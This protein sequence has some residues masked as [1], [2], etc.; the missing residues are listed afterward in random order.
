MATATEVLALAAAELGY[1]RWDDPAEGTKYGRWYAKVTGSPYFGTSG[2]AF[3]AMGVSYVLAKAGMV[4][5]G[6]IFAYVPYGINN[7]KNLG[8]LVPV[9]AAQPGDLICFDWDNDGLSDHVGF[10]ELNRGSYVQTIEF[11]TS[12]SHAGSQSNSGGVYRR[13]RYWDSVCAVIRPD[14]NGAASI[15]SGEVAEFE[16]VPDG[17]W[18]ANTNRD[19]QRSQGTTQD[20][21]I[22]S[23]SA[24]WRPMLVACTSGWEFVA[25]AEA[26]GSQL[27]ASMQRDMGLDP[28]A[29]AGVDFINALEVRYGFD[30]DGCLDGPSPTVRAMQ[31]SLAKR[32]RF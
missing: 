30:P 25:P 23:Q 19:L 4:P 22:S 29:L 21:K 10:V 28:D 12:G 32:G 31:L 15:P 26:E 18:G 11:N 1:N 24:Y 14:Y 16:T 27:I 2:V 20:G 9:R 3:C 13:T 5:P 7:A 17:W 8:R 6:G